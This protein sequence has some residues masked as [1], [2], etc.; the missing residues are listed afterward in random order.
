MSDQTFDTHLDAQFCRSV[1]EI[2]LPTIDIPANEW[3][4][5]NKRGMWQVKARR[6]KAVRL[7]ANRIMLG[8]K[9]ANHAEYQRVKDSPQVRVI[10]IAHMLTTGRYDPANIEPMVKPILDAL[11]DLGFWPDDDMTH[12]L[13]VDYRAGAR[14]TTRG[15]HGVE[16]HIQPIENR[17]RS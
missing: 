9:N 8:W 14:N 10:A 12:V 7:R 4:T 11:T 6:T 5:S 16:I 2:C 13:G 1:G 3:H 15:W 17:S